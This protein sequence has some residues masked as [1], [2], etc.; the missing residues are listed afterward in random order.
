MRRSAEHWGPSEC[1]SLHVETGAVMSNLVFAH[2]WEFIEWACQHRRDRGIWGRDQERCYY[3]IAADNGDGPVG[4]TP[5][6]GPDATAPLMA[7]SGEMAT[8]APLSPGVS[9]DEHTGMVGVTVSS[10]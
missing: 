4:A 8:V 9:V 3:L 6:P 10:T 1:L 5:T 7:R 2:C